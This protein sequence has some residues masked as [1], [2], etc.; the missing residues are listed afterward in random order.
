[1]S[2]DVSRLFDAYDRGRLTRRQLFQALGLT[3]LAAPLAA[4][5][6]E[7]P[8]SAARGEPPNTE[9][10]GPPFSPTRWGTTRRRRPTS[11]P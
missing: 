1:M 2:Q 9:P 10:G 6:R 11:T 8:R 7:Q 5:A 3:A 4:L